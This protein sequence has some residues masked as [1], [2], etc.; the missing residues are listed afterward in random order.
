[1][2]ISVNA[3]LGADGSL[4][5]DAGDISLALTARDCKEQTAS[6]TLC[7]QQV[8]LTVSKADGSLNQKLD[9]A[10]VFV[11]SDATLYRGPLDKSYKQGGHSFVLTDLN[12][13]GHDDLMVWAGLEGAYGGP[14]FD[15][16]LF[17]S[18]KREFVFDQDFSDLTIGANGLFSVESGKIKVA[19]SDGCCLHVFDTYAVESN[20]PVLV[21]RVTEDTTAGEDKA[22]T[23]TEKRIDGEMKEVKA[24]P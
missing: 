22:V 8:V 15:V 3:K 16:Y 4:K 6:L 9:P 13:D 21:E 23:K 5:L 14:S 1:M 10:A 2:P 12:N 11:K 18:A 24:S 17:D 19:S 20:K 7:N